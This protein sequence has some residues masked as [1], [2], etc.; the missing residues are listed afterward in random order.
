LALARVLIHP[1]QE[2]R[3]MPR[4]ILT[5]AVLLGVLATVPAFAEGQERSRGDRGSSRSEGR[6]GGDGSRAV[7]R[8]PDRAPQSR[9]YDR[10]RQYDGPQAR[11][12]DRPRQ[13]DG[14]Q[15]QARRYDD[16]RRAYARPYVYSNRGYDRRDYRYS[17]RNYRSY[18][19]RGYVGRDYYRGSYGYGYGRRISPR[20][21][22]PYI[23]GYY[24]YRPYY[25]RPRFGLNIY[26]GVDGSYPYGYTPRGYY[27]PIPGRSYGG[28][29]I[30]DA[31]REAQVFADGYYV[32]IVDDFDG[33]FQ[34]VNLEAG[35]HQI[36]VRTPGD[37]PIAFDIVV[38]PGRVMTL[39]ADAY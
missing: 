24:S 1:T 30:T 25:Y 13:Y 38:Q 9:S 20:Y 10:P 4:R 39:R 3:M 5:G 7:Q 11:S 27:D 29:R 15:N 6:R 37:E 26:Y 21:V 32:G 36:E 8:A 12:Y 17:D 31:P 16:S 18:S 33:V 22:R 35:E 23:S 2:I 34:H 14:R 19:N 28:V